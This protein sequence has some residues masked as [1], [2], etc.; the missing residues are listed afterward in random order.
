M[1]LGVGGF[2]EP[3][4][5]AEVGSGVG[6]GG[7]GIEDDGEGVTDGDEGAEVDGDGSATEEV[8]LGVAD[9]LW[10]VPV[11]PV[12][13]PGVGVTSARAGSASARQTAAVS[14]ATAPRRTTV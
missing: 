6:S 2:V 3:L 9:G 8:G 7:T 11:G 1:G 10:E 4:G 12:V 14:A 13:E 5:L